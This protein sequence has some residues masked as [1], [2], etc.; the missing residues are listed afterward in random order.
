MNNAVRMGIIGD[1]NPALDS[2]LKTNEALEHTAE[3]LSIDLNIEWLGTDSLEN[4][5][6]EE[7]MRSFHGFLCA[8]GSPYKSTDGALTAIKFSRENGWPLLAT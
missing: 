3:F 5:S 7:I 4:E 1:F 2:H 8:P 6:A